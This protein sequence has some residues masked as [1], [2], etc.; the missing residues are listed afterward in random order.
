M[1]RNSLF[2]EIQSNENIGFVLRVIHASEISRNMLRAEPYNLNAMSHDAA[3][4][5]IQAVLDAGVTIDTCYIDSVGIADTYRRK[6]EKEFMGHDVKF[7]VEKKADGTP[8]PT[9]SHTL[10]TVTPGT[11]IHR[12]PSFSEYVTNLSYL[13]E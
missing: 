2:D 6:L 1:T 13:P 10:D 9:T 3:I 11:S 12:R 7:V 8:L 4:Q 5:M